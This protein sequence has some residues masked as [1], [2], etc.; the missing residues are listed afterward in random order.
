MT[1]LYI[2]IRVM[3]SSGRVVKKNKS[4]K[5]QQD[6]CVREIGGSGEWLF[7]WR[8][9]FFQWEEQLFNMLKEGLHG[10]VWSPGDVD[11]WCWKLTE[12][13]VFFR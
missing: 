1:V 5:F 11:S 9:R 13:C 4:R 12:N 2:R 6:A 10:F 3:L 7:D 8:R